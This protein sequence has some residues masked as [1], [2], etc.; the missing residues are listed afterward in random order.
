M[1]CRKKNSGFVSEQKGT[2]KFRI[3]TAFQIFLQ[4]LFVD[5]HAQYGQELSVRR[6][7]QGLGD[8]DKIVSGPGIADE[9]AGFQLLQNG[10]PV[11]LGEGVGIEGHVGQKFLLIR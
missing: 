2:G 11:F 7:E 3:Q 10:L 6:G 4:A 1:S 5:L 9:P 8:G